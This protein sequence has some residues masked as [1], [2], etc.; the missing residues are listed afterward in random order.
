MRAREYGTMIHTTL[1]PSAVLITCASA[2]LLSGCGG[3][4][5][6]SA[7]GASYHYIPT[8]IRHSDRFATLR[9]DPVLVSSLEA[10][11]HREAYAQDEIAELD[12]EWIH[13]GPEGTP[14]MNELLSGDASLALA[15]HQKTHPEWRELFLIDRTGCLTAAS[16]RTS[17]FWQ[18]DE[19]K[20][21]KVFV[22]APGVP[23]VDDIAFDRSTQAYIYHYSMPVFDADDDLIGVLV[24][25]VA[26]ERTAS[27]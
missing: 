16:Q 13:A 22:D 12:Q 2:F 23:Y 27:R 21:S 11:N 20:W 8:Q 17:D 19:A 14:F 24:I 5:S 25:G 26:P 1:A 9:N 4:R 7:A 10:A 18:G 15:D 6:E 3:V